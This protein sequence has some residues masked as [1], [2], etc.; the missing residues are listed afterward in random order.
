MLTRRS[1]GQ[2]LALLERPRKLSWVDLLVVISLLGL[3]YGLLKLGSEW[4]GQYQE[5]ADLDL[6]PSA[7]PLYTFYSL[8]RGL[9]AYAISLGFTLVYGYWAAKDPLAERVLVPLLDILQS[10]PVLGFLPAVSLAF[11]A[12]FPNRN[13]GLEL[14]CIVM[15]F[16][17]Q[18]WNMTF[19]FY[20]SVKSVPTDQREVATVYRFSWW[21]RFKW[22]EVP[23]AT[24]GLV[25]N[26][27]MSM[28]GGWFF[29]SICEA[30]SLEVGGES[31]KFRLPGVGSFMAQAYK[32]G[33]TPAF[34]YALLALVIMIVAVD[35]LLWRPIVVWATKFRVE[36]GGDQEMPT[37]WFLDLLRRSSIIALT[38]VIVRLL[39]P[40]ERPGRPHE[41]KKF[42]TRPAAFWFERFAFVAFVALMVGLGLG[43]WKLILLL[44][45]VSWEQWYAIAVGAGAT[46]LRVL[47]ATALGTLWAVPA[48]LAIGFAP[49]F[50]RIL[51]P[52]VQVVA[53]F[54]FP[55]LF[56]PVAE[57][58]NRFGVG[59]G[60]GSI[61]LML[62]GTQWYIL[63]NVIAGASAIPADLREMGQSYRFGLWQRFRDIYFPGI[64]PYLV[65]GWVTAAGAAWNA[66]IVSEIVEIREG[67]FL[68]TRGLGAEITV[69]GGL[70]DEPRNIPLLAACVLVMSALV[71]C[72]N[73]TVWRRCYRLA[74]E[75]FSLNK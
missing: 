21:Q 24:I 23:Y 15:I 3:F 26:S 13:V 27:M 64:F 10:I 35:Q 66:S 36:E 9:I 63:F 16:T 44:S 14:V 38:G 62:L 42:D 54:P 40:D 43:V 52:V 71:V 72:F 60:W 48:G 45:G 73:R 58:L 12:L 31:R 37:S 65:T 68:S 8:C 32:E 74:E 53:S 70:S 11:L 30:F 20:R 25:W 34:L 7:L 5:T 47:A 59:L 28:A 6:S 41:G 75:R 49:R 46:L 51:Q 33:Q 67:T 69:A 57:G 2:A 56:G 29:L 22:V 55:L 50:N 61:L 39:L 18:A 17:G 1:W 4:R 19:S